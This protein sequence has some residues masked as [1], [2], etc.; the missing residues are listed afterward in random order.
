MDQRTDEW[1]AM[2]AGKF[3][4][5]RFSELMAKTRNGWGKSR[6]N[7]VATL[8]QER[9]TGKCAPTY[10]NAAMQ[11]GTDLEP[12]ARSAYEAHAGVL[13]EEVAFIEH[14]TIPNVGISPDGL[15][16]DEGLVEIKCPS[17][18]DKHLQ[19]RLHGA[20]AKE[21]K[22]QLQGQLWVTGKAWVDAAS[23]DPRWPDAH[24]LAIVRVEPD[25]KAHAELAAAV[26]EAE[27]E[28]A[29]IIQQLQ[30]KSA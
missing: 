17:S 22:W 29:A 7:L 26:Q 16:G 24:K 14:P 27:E 11:R 3:T 18:M 13:V 5:S 30:E 23:Y 1:L 15:V 8:V 28:I 6:N 10:C 12:E 25:P 21:Y 9:M 4:G 2:R 20:H 19:A